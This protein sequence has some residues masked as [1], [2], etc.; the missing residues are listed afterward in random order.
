MNWQEQR[1]LNQAAQAEQA[2]QDAIAA[3]QVEAIRSRTQVEAVAADRAQRA[4]LAAAQR[5]ERLAEKKQREADRKARWAALRGW[6]SAHTVDLLIYPLAVVSAVMAIP[7]MATFGHEVYGTAAGYAL[8]VITEL[9]MWAFAFAVHVARTRSERDGQDRPVWALQLGVW[10][11]ATVAAA[12]NFLHGLTGPGLSAG[13]VMATASVAGVMAHQLVTAAPRRGRAERDAARIERQAAAKVTAVRQ[14][15]VRAAVAR[16]DEQGQARLVFQPGH[17]Q[18]TPPRLAR[19]LRIGRRVRLETAAVPGLPVDPAIEGEWDEMDRE[20]ARLLATV[21]P[22][23]GPTTGPT[24]NATGGGIGTL[25]PAPETGPETGGDQQE[26]TPIDRGTDRGSKPARTSRRKA[27][28]IA[29]ERRS[30]EDLR[31]E[32]A[33]RIEADPTS[34]NPLSAESIRKALRCSPERARALRDS[35]RDDH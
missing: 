22:Y 28:R 19:W 12:L 20:L 18:L 8:P 21:D 23:P 34:V 13:L 15:A 31:A 29:P 1:R 6:A 27:K 35:Y 30:I 24:H 2:R 9:G 17:Y 16:I 10:S 3:A 32:L 26:S 33:A 25:D 5:A 14:A 4:E 11:F 7:A